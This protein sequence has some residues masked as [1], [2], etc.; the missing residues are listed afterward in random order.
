MRDVVVKCLADASES[1]DGTPLPAYPAGRPR[2]TL[3]R[4]V[5]SLVRIQSPRQ[6]R[7]SHLQKSAGG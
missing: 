1:W 7:I 4:G 2:V 3:L 5:W 6:Q